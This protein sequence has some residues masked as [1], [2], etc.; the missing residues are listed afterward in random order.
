MKNKLQ[1]LFLVL[2]AVLFTG[3][4]GCAEK[5]PSSPAAEAPPVTVVLQDLTDAPGGYDQENDTFI[6][7]YHSNTNTGGCN[8]LRVGA[9]TAFTPQSRKRALI[10]FGTNGYIPVTAT[11]VVSATLDLYCINYSGSC[12][13]SVYALT[14]YFQPGNASCAGAGGMPEDAS[15]AVHGTDGMALP[16]GWTTAGGDYNPVKIGGPLQGISPAAVMSFSLDTAAVLNWIQTPSSNYGVILIEDS[17]AVAIDHSINFA[18]N[19]EAVFANRP[20]LT[21]VYR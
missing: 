6:D 13:V 7:S 2:I 5:S 16:E 19:Q 1:F 10:K 11:A 9:E 20:K 21:V 15:W 18:S 8:Y 12:F 4:A 3:L 17:E 14:K